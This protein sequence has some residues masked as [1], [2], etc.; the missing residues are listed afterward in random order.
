MYFNIKCSGLTTPEDTAEKSEPCTRM[1]DH[2]EGPSLKYSL[3]L[4]GR[5]WN[6][7]TTKSVA[8]GNVIFPKMMN[9]SW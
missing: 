3:T 5:V 1:L 8:I 9:N 7:N 2:R 6:S 4:R